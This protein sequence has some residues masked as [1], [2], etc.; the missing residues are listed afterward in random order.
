MLISAR[1]TTAHAPDIGKGRWSWPHHLL[2]DSQLM[3]YINKRGIKLLSDLDT[4]GPERSETRNSQILW[5]EFID[6]ITTKAR[7][8]AKISISKLEREIK[9]LEVDL[10]EIAADEGM[11]DEERTLSSAVKLDKLTSLMRQRHKGNRVL[12]RAQNILEGEVIS[13][14]WSQLNKDHRP[15]EVIQCLIKKTFTDAEGNTHHE[16]RDTLL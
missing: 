15:R 16:Y 13:C 7:E 1:V 4:L 6:D 3:D 11:S 12:V 2:K 5:D 9:N 8:R 10:D 14:Y